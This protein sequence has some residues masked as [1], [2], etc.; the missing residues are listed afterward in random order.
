MFNLH[1]K[2]IQSMRGQQFA[3]T[4]AASTLELYVK[5]RMKE[6]HAGY[7]TCV[8]SSLQE[9]LPL[10]CFVQQSRAYRLKRAAVASRMASWCARGAA[11]KRH[12]GKASHVSSVTVLIKLEG[13]LAC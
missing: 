12:Q 5:T 13:K 3:G 10:I 2:Q 1:R 4:G 6:Q 8:C 9:P 11:D 7:Y